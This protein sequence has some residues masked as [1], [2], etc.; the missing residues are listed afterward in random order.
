MELLALRR[1]LGIAAGKQGTRRSQPR[2]MLV[3]LFPP[4]RGGVTTFLLNLVGSSLAAT[5][6]FEPYTI[7]RPPKE[8]V[9]DNWGYAAVFRGGIRRIALGLLIT[10]WRILC[11]PCAVWRRHI[12]IVQVQAS[13]YQQFWEAALYVTIARALRRPVLMRLGGAFDLFY[14]GSSPLM[15]RCIKRA[16]ALPDLLIVQS[17]Y[18]RDMLAGLGRRDGVVVLN[19]F[20]LEDAVGE[21]RPLTGTPPACL[22]IAGSEARRK[23]LDV[24]LDALARLK[25][26]GVAA[27]IVMIG[28]PPAAAERIRAAGLAGMV[29]MRGALSRQEVLEEM[30][31]TEV[32]LLPSFGEG[33][34]NSLVE[35][36]A[37]GMA[38]VVT[39]VGSVPEV[40]GD[41][42]GAIVVPPGD[43]EALAAAI[44]RLIGSPESC[45]RMGGSNQ[46][47]VRARFTSGAVLATLDRAYRQLLRTRHDAAT[48]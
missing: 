40:V 7:S 39:P 36:M 16:I 11:F 4:A 28:V 8:N 15:K 10:A 3:G 9:V 45:A 33:F 27:R 19:N 29:E 25:R 20:I 47:I 30:R 35:A 44:A 26:D 12:D 5:Y 18:W 32:F 42:E 24:L 21:A 22:F 48:P 13:D 34:P 37:Q 38:T 1:P 43:A 6:G 41:G 17:E 46:A 23:G 14:G 31:R 2:V